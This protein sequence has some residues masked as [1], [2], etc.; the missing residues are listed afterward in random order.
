MIIGM[1][2][3]TIL[4]AAISVVSALTLTYLVW[5]EGQKVNRNNGMAA[6]HRHLDALSD[7]SRAHL[8]QQLQE[9]RERQQGR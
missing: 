9:S 4:F 1:T 5:Q 8:R 2:P 7:D 6:F 3:L